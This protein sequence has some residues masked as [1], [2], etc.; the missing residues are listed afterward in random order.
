MAPKLLDGVGTTTNAIILIAY[1]VGNAAGPFMWKLEYQPRFVSCCP[2]PCVYCIMLTRIFSNHI[3][4]AV[5]SA[6][7]VTCMLLILLLR[8]ML[9][10]ENRRRDAEETEDPYDAVYISR[11]LPNGSKSEKK[12]DR[13]FLDLTDIQNREFR[14]A[15]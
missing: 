2:P 11:E 7:I 8:F 14:Y 13:A 6:C 12:V 4:W 3:P 9:A 15:L 5:I 1:A 10:A